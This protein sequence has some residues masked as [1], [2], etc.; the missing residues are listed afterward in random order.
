LPRHRSWGVKQKKVLKPK[1]LNTRSQ[2][3]DCFRERTLN[4]RSQLSISIS[5][6]MKG[7]LLLSSNLSRPIT[8]SQCPLNLLPP[9]EEAWGTQPV[10]HAIAI[11]SLHK[12]L[13]ELKSM[14]RDRILQKKNSRIQIRAARYHANQAIYIRGIGEELDLDRFRHHCFNIWP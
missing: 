5:S 13:L 3:P 4:R 12:Q 1:R 11:H 6:R 7:G 8:R 10:P 9:Q 2:A 14:L